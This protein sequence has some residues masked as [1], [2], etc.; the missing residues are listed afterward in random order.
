MSNELKKINSKTITSICLSLF[1][2]ILAT[3]FYILYSYESKKCEAPTSEGC[4]GGI[5]VLSLVIFFIPLLFLIII[6]VDILTRNVIKNINN[7]SFDFGEGFVKKTINLCR[8]AE[9]IS[10]LP[11]IVFVLFIFR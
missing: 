11:L 1:N 3:I 10:V 5:I 7:A 8:L 9:I 4:S 6:I 2:I